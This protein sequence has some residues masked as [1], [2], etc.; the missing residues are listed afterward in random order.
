MWSPHD[1]RGADEFSRHGDDR[2][3]FAEPASVAFY[4][5]APGL[6]AGVMQINVQIPAGVAARDL[7]VSVTVGSA[8]TQSGVTVSVR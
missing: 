4:G 6:V 8:V 5:E 7:P 2:D 1:G 3:C